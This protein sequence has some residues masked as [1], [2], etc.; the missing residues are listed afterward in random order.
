MYSGGYLI[1]HKE[2]K[3]F[4]REISRKEVPKY[5]EDVSVT[6]KTNVRANKKEK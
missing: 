2:T 5:P 4:S 1:I 3:S 6:S